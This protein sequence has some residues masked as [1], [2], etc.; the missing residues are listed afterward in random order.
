MHPDHVLRRALWA[1]AGFNALGALAFGWPATFGQLAGLPA[2]AP[3][4]YRAA[5]GFLVALLGATYAWL[6]LQ[7]RIDRPLIG[8]A[9]FG[10]AGFFVVVVLCWLAGEAPLLGVV[11]AAGDLA[12]A[13]LFAWWL[14]AGDEPDA[15]AAR[16]QVGPSA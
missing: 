12:F 2:E 16:A 11:T 5:L 7:P 9:M 6:A 4:V 10:K 13:A 3:V 1:T 14:L 15:A 8:F